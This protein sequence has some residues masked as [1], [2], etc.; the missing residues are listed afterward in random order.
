MYDELNNEYIMW[1]NFDPDGTTISDHIF[2]IQ[3]DKHS[4]SPDF[5]WDTRITNILIS[6]ASDYDFLLAYST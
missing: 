3:F 1:L 4:T 5:D 2:V 6:D